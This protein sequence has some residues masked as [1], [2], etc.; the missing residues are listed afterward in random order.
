MI[1]LILSL[2]F[3]S[4]IAV[5][6]TTSMARSRHYGGAPPSDTYFGSPRNIPNASLYNPSK[7]PNAVYYGGTHAGSDPDPNIRTRSFASSADRSFNQSPPP[8]VALADALLSTYGWRTR[9]PVH[10]SGRALECQ[11]PRSPQNECEKCG[12]VQE[13]GLVSPVVRSGHPQMSPT[14]V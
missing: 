1:R 8:S 9:S 10:V 14:P 13:I 3:A 6:A 7:D 5:T 11:W 12:E 2:L 4:A